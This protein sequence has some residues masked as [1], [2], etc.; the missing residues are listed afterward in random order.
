M[1]DSHAIDL[2]DDDEL[3]Y[4]RVSVRSGWYD[5]ETNILLRTAFN[6]SAERD[7]T[8]IS[9]DR[10]RSDKHPHFRTIEQA[11]TGPSPDG[12]YIAVFRVGDLR[13]HNIEVVAKPVE[14]NPG[15]AELPDLRHVNKNTERFDNIVKML[16]ENLRLRV[17]GPF[18]D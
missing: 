3:L 14:H 13:A 11:A 9:L 7:Q 12:Y 8:G 17:E 18:H 16:T 2:I 4:R 6:P 15:H 10:A 5:P 1:A